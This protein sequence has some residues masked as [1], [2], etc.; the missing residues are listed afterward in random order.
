MN[1]SHIEEPRV[2]TAAADVSYNAYLFHWPFYVIFSALF[3]SN[4]TAALVTLALTF[5]FA[6]LLYYQAER[7]FIPKGKNGALKYRGITI[8]LVATLAV[9]AAGLGSAAIYRAPAITSIEK[10]FMISYA[11]QDAESIAVM[12]RRAQNI[13]EQ[14]VHTLYSTSVE[15]VVPAVLISEPE[16][17]AGPAAL[18]AMPEQPIA[19][20]LT[21]TKPKSPPAV[22]GITGGI[23]VIG[24]SVA[25][26]ASMAIQENITDLDLDADIGRHL[27]HG[28]DILTGYQDRGELREYVVVSLGTNG[29][30]TYEKHFTDIIDAL[31]PGHKLIIVTPFDGR[32]NDNAKWVAKIADYIRELPEIYDFITVADWNAAIGTQTELLAADKV[33][34]YAMKSQAAD[35]FAECITEALNEAAGK[36][37][38]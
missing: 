12:A 7:I 28:V 30:N 20:A 11:T 29:T 9:M 33:H 10:S 31:N 4:M 3:S 34:L 26:G 13:N 14:V 35:I 22:E 1:S 6:A 36:P 8:A 23:T 21:V 15:M 2:L 19:T 27:Y 37:A 16:A 32:A 24:D 38:K 25:L 5:I 18:N 17:L